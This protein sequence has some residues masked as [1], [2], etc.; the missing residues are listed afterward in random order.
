MKEAASKVPAQDIATKQKMLGAE[1]SKLGIAQKMQALEKLK[2]EQALLIKNDQLAI[3]QAQ[4]DLQDAALNYE[5]TKI[6]A[7]S[8]GTVRDRAVYTT[9]TDQAKVSK[10]DLL[11]AEGKVD[12]AIELAAPKKK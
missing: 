4:L 2:R 10:F 11:I 3:A 8:Q 9:S 7:G 5:K 1:R 6:E 12:E